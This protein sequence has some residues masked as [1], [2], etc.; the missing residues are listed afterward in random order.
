MIATLTFH[1]DRLAALAPPGS[2]WPPTSPSGWSARACRSAMA[3]ELAGACVR[4][5]EA[6]GIELWELTDADLAA[7]A[8]ARSRPEVRDGAHRRG[9]DRVADARGGTAPCASRE[10]L[11][12]LRDL[13][14]RD[15]VGARPDE[16]LP[17]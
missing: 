4:A 17:A 2:R 1:T 8:P 10:Q 13:R 5:C 9:L 6:R 12:E 14:R 7:I 3:H 16:R 11:A 15:G